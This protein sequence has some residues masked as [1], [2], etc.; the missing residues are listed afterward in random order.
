[1]SCNFHKSELNHSVLVCTQW[2]P[3]CPLTPIE[4]A[5]SC[6]S[7]VF[8]QAWR[9]LQ[10]LKSSAALF[11]SQ[12]HQKRRENS[13]NPENQHHL[14]AKIWVWRL[15]QDHFPSQYNTP[16]PEIGFLCKNAV[17]CLQNNNFS[18]SSPGEERMSWLSWFFS[19][20]FVSFVFFFFWWCYHETLLVPLN[21]AQEKQV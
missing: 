4:R 12:W 10:S 5:P 15:N 7:R 3:L 16:D 11:T 9:C 19:K 8:L 1:M 13:E 21:T 6:L 17:L 18:L 14:S 20:D 2:F